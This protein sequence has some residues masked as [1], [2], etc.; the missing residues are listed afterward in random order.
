M[1]GQ[2]SDFSGSMQVNNGA[3]ILSTDVVYDGSH[4]IH[5]LT[6]GLDGKITDRPFDT[7]TNQFKTSKVL[8]TSGATLSGYYLGTCGI[9]AMMDNSQVLHVAFWAS[10]NHI[11]YRSYTY[12]SA[13]DV[14]TLVS[15]PT[16][17]D[18]SGNANHPSWRF[19]P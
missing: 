9:S 1:P 10:G 17:L 12:N 4:I 15:G 16:Q 13:T 14:L 7:S 5:V 11:T 3:N 18:T 8:D 2:G 19:L 6:N